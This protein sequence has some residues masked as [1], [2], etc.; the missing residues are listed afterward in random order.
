MGDLTVTSAEG[1]NVGATKLTAD[2][3]LTAGQHFVYKV[4]N[5]ST[6]PSIGYHEEPDYTW[7]G[8]D[9]TSD[10]SVGASADGYKVTV[11]VLNGSNKAIKSG[12][13]AMDVKTA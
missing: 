9:G 13:V 11:A 3:S 2:Y 4:G 1:T 7:T 5:A 10:I 12:N 6:A 8:W